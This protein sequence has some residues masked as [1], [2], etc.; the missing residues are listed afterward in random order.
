[1][2]R[3]RVALAGARVLAEVARRD[4]SPDSLRAVRAAIVA[5]NLQL[6]ADTAG[7]SASG[8]GYNP[9]RDKGG[10]FA[11][12]AHKQK[13]TAG[14]RH[15]AAVAKAKER[16]GKAKA[17]VDKHAAKL[18]AAHEA[19]RAAI[20]ET[21]AALSKAHAAADLARAKPTAK[22]VRAAQ[23]ATNKATRA[24][25]KVG[26][27]EAAIAKHTEAHAKATAAHAKA[28][29]AHAKVAGKSRDIGEGP[30]AK[31]D[32][33]KADASKAS[34]DAHSA[35]T[36]AAR[37]GTKQSHEAAAKA[38]ESAAAAMTGIGNHSRAAGHQE[39]ARRHRDATGQSASADHASRMSAEA[40]AASAKANAAGS[41]G[42]H[43]DAVAA[44]RE[45]AYAHEQAGSKA[46]ADR[47]MQMVDRHEMAASRAGARELDAK[48]QANRSKQ[49][50]AGFKNGAFDAKAQAAARDDVRGELAKHGITP[51]EP[52][53]AGR[54][55]LKV[56]HL[57]DADAVFDPTTHGVSIAPQFASHLAEYHSS[58]RAELGRTLEHS[59][60][61]AARTAAYQKIISQHN[62]I[63]EQIHASGIMAHYEGH[64]VFA[65]E[66]VTEMAARG[67]TAQAHGI[68]QYQ[69][70]NAGYN[71]VLTPAIQHLATASGKS[72]EEAHEALSRVSVAFKRG[73]LT[74]GR[75]ASAPVHGENVIHMVTKRALGELG[76]N[77]PAVHNHV[78]GEFLKIS[79]TL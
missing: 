1:M 22:N 7:V 35:S 49:V 73:D 31:P 54:N 46:D 13:P 71:D 32:H 33:A 48:T 30:A 24:A 23:V 9:Y 14:E 19:K 18:G 61:Q 12:G 36:E 21:R 42:A 51:R 66:M 47:H 25:A 10:K 58:N 76:Q 68:S 70:T 77:S 29:E 60:D 37:A 17:T 56:E 59:Q 39:M 78:Y 26:K 28:V 65:E 67:V 44:H 75:S 11:P 55:T 43:A 57:G 69:L 16:V 15:A 41:S 8:H 50:V 38:H 2:I 40:D 74:P 45:A 3:A 6:R 5:V 27:H 4:P 63:H 20:A 53:A 79:A 64:G 62:L 34:S 72:F 52:H